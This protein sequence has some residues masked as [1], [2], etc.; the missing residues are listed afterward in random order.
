MKYEYQIIE[1][2]GISL[3]DLEVALNVLGC[4]G[5]ELISVNNVAAF[6]MRV[7]LDAQEYIDAG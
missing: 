2:P 5:W 4:D 7:V 3:P 6:L 1:L